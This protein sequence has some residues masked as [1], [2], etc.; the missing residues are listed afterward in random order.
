VSQ[1]QI[2]SPRPL[3]SNAFL[4]FGG[5]R[6]GSWSQLA[7]RLVPDLVPTCTPHEALFLQRLY[8]NLG[9]C[10]TRKKV[11]VQRRRLL[12]RRCPKSPRQTYT[13]S[14]ARPM[15]SLMIPAGLQ[16]DPPF[17]RRDVSVVS[18]R[19]ADAAAD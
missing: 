17:K 3:I 5:T 12:L 19:R 8:C 6:F 14:R 7:T 1:V 9:N 11:P 10:L 16:D 4:T 2:L 15:N 13:P 18:V